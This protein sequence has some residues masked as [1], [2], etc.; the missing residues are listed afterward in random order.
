MD[1]VII[2]SM[3]GE[4][5]VCEL[6]SSTHDELPGY[7]MVARPRIFQFQNNNGKM[8]PSL[9]PWVMLDPDNREVP[10]NSNYI[11]SMMPA[12]ATLTKSYIAAVSGIALS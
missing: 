3:I 12:S 8:E 11:A 1:V 10:L 9:V 7:I 6:V 2:K 4:E 5:L